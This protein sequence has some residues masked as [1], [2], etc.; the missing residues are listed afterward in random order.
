MQTNNVFYFHKIVFITLFSSC[1][2]SITDINILT[3]D[4]IP[5]ISEKTKN[6][7]KEIEKTCSVKLNYDNYSNSNDFLNQLSSHD[8]DYDIVIAPNTFLN[9]IS[10]YIPKNKNKELSKIVENY[11]PHVKAHYK[12]I[13]TQN[14]VAYFIQSITGILIN[15]EKIDIKKFNNI[16]DL[17]ESLKKEDIFIILDDP[18]E[19]SS[20]IEKSKKNKINISAEKIVE[21]IKD[22][23]EKIENKNVTVVNF[24]NDRMRDKNFTAAISWSG[25]AIDDINTLNNTM[26]K[27][28]SFET[29]KWLSF[30]S[31]DL[32]IQLNT[33]TK[34]NCTMLRLSSKDFLDTI[35]V[36][37]NYFSPFIDKNKLW[38]KNNYYHE[39][40]IKYL[41]F[42]KNSDWLDSINNDQF[43]KVQYEWEKFK[44]HTIKERKK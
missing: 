29:P 32:I 44:F 39:I 27:N 2:L 4:G 37:T 30:I 23:T 33:K 14:N 15:N 36:E 31:S 28:F 19:L 24:F 26:K 20:I 9:L 6:K 17:I 22:F 16:Y 1:A 8:Y 5:N 25:S 10:K 13:K 35:A 12:S 34:T 43:N 41:D 18:V 7:V 11:N 3:W 38:Y 42:L 40:Q 21:N